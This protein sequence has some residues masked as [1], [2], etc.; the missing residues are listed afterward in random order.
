MSRLN[1]IGR[2]G[3]GFFVSAFMLFG[4]AAPA[5]ALPSCTNGGQQSTNDIVFC[6]AFS[7]SELQAKIDNG[8]G[9]NSAA[10]LK[11]IFFNQGRGITMSEIMSSDTVNG[12]VFR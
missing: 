7:K 3:L 1:V 10:N 2:A 4:L 11:D 12:T 8:D 9:V 5:S 6:G